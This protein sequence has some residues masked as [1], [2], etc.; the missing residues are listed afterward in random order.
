MTGRET[1]YILEPH[2]L[3]FYDGL[4]YVKAVIVSENGERFDGV[5]EDGVCKL[6][7]RSAFAGSIATA[8]TLIKTLVNE[9]K[10]PI[11]EAVGMLTEVPA[12]IMN[13]RKELLIPN[14]NSQKC[15]RM[16]HQ[17]LLHRCPKEPP[18]PVRVL[19]VHIRSLPATRC[20][21]IR[22][23]FTAEVLKTFSKRLTAVFAATVFFPLK[24]A[25]QVRSTR[26]MTL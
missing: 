8:D 6:K 10:I 23:S 21:P 20:L 18:L 16:Q 2:V 17:A 15:L 19:R 9:V 22:Q 25:P 11:P 5:I 4:W 13:I 7:D 3:S 14:Q 12:K 1:R 24:T 26:S